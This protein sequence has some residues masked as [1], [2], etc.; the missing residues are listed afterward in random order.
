MKK[1]PPNKVIVCDL[2]GTLAS[3]K[4]DLTVG[5]ATTLRGLLNF[6]KFAVISG[7]SYKQ[8][9]K[10]FISPLSAT[11]EQ[12]KNL[13]LFPVNGSTCYTFDEATFTWKQLYDKSFTEEERKS[14]TT[15]LMESLNES[16]I[17]IGKTF[18]EL[19]EDRG[20]QVTFS[21]LGQ[22]APLELKKN[23]DPNQQKR[24]K[25]VEK[26][27]PK[28]P[29]A[30]IGIGGSTSI[31]ITHKGIDKAYAIEYLQY[32]LHLTDADVVFLG[33]ALYEHGN[34]EPAKKTGVLCIQV[35]NPEETEL[36]IHDYVDSRHGN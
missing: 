22:L 16:G 30:H 11:S 26:L 13:Y 5:M 1:I 35:E 32:L 27:T 31:D 18:G 33:D 6:Q 34:D 15:A 23:W 17:E 25:I 12:L 29:E 24:E 19:I 2:D 3:S 36:L 21:G 20:E 14:I 10:Q 4:E 7:G 28:I 9:Q 8:F